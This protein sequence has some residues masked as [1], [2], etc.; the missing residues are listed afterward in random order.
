MENSPFESELRTK[1]EEFISALPDEFSGVLIETSFRQYHVKISISVSGNE[2]GKVS[3][4]YAPTKKSFTL[5]N[6]GLADDIFSKIEAI[7][8]GNFQT[9]NELTSATTQSNDIVHIYVDGSFIRGKVGYGL[10][11]LQNNKVVGEFFGSV[12]NEEY[13]A[14]R[15]V[16]GELFAM[17]KAVQW[18]K[19]NKI[20]NIT[21]FYDYLGIECWVTGKW[22]A[23]LP[24]TQRYAQFVRSS[25]IKI[26]WQKVAAHTGNFWNERADE[27][28]KQGA[29]S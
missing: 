27:L 14:T 18:C 23:K 7:F 19:I 4:Y 17:G 13:V 1:A 5:K 15:Q 2:L 16:A 9:K 28:A 20:N 29:M 21:V 12:E 22:K 24:L 10:I 3:L 25:G 26:R 8:S 6:A 11:I